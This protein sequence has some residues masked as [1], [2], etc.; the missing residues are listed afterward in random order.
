MELRVRARFQAGGWEK[1]AVNP[2]PKHLKI[3][4]FRSHFPLAMLLSNLTLWG[5]TEIFKAFAVNSPCVTFLISRSHWGIP[6]LTFYWLRH[7]QSGKEPQHSIVN[8]PGKFHQ[9]EESDKWNK[10]ENPRT[11]VCRSSA[12]LSSYTEALLSERQ[13]NL[14]ACSALTSDKTCWDTLQTRPDKNAYRRKLMHHFP[15]TIPI[16]HQKFTRELLDQDNFEQGAGR[17]RLCSV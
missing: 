17:G 15:F 9:T 13:R 14:M 8:Y 5:V 10:S 1:K 12:A 6:N 2:W 7:K 16:Y 11:V 4:R 3:V